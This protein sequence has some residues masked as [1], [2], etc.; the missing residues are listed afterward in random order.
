MK[1]SLS[2]SLSGFTTS[3][4]PFV[5]A[6][7]GLTANLAGIWSVMR[8]L[9]SA[10][11]GALIRVRRSSDDTELDIYPLAD[12]SLDT[13]TL[14]AFVGAGDGFVRIVYGQDGGVNLVN[15][16]ASEQMLIVSGGVLVVD[17]DGYPAMRNPSTKWIQSESAVSWKHWFMS[18]DTGPAIL[19]NAYLFDARTDLNEGYLY[20]GTVYGGRD[21]TLLRK[22]GAATTQNP[23]G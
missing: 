2:T 11:P 8:R 23:A 12:G 9:L 7:D 16:S 14:L 5:G 22:N 3:A 10:Y 17:G 13:V 1:L 20:D 18:H 6:M 21:W 4:A 15:T 19:D